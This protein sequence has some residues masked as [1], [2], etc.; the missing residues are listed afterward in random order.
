MIL[1]RVTWAEDWEVWFS[2]LSLL[3]QTNARETFTK[4]GKEK[5]KEKREKKAAK[6]N[7]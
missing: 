3:P 1:E 4:G 5:K 6:D 2:I 7:A